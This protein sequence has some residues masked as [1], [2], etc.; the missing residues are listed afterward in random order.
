M[1]TMEGVVR[2]KNGKEVVDHRHLPPHQ[3]LHPHIHLA[4]LH[5][6]IVPSALIRVQRR[7]RGGGI[8]VGR[9]PKTGGIVVAGEVGT[10][11]KGMMT[12][13]D[14]TKGEEVAADH[15]DRGTSPE[16]GTEVAGSVAIDGTD[17]THP[18]IDE[19]RRLVIGTVDG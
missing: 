16:T 17:L 1:T 11:G 2:E 10:D 14:T 9:N 15:E 6:H 3:V 5:D 4:H 8:A 13:T 12:G 18:M 19:D 7:E